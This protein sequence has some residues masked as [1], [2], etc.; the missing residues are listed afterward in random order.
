M[1]SEIHGTEGLVPLRLQAKPMYRLGSSIRNLFVTPEAQ[2]AELERIP[3]GEGRP[4]PLTFYSRQVAYL[5]LGTVARR[6]SADDIAADAAYSKQIKGVTRRMIDDET[7]P[8][9]PVSPPVGIHFTPQGIEL[10]ISLALSNA[11]DRTVVVAQPLFPEGFTDDVRMFTRIARRK[12]VGGKSLMSAFESFANL[13]ESD[14]ETIKEI[15]EL[16][17]LALTALKVHHQFVRPI[18]SAMD[19]E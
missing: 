6:G 10:E 8:I 16:E 1:S 17:P 14:N 5:D 4:Q 2:D 3:L 11:E 12:L 13:V 18:S 19:E 15:P 7:S 9:F